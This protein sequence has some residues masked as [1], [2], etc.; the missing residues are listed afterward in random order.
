MMPAA[1]AK[2]VRPEISWM[3]SFGHEVLPMFF[4]GLDADAEFRRGLLVGLAF[5]NQLEHL[6]LARTQES[7]FLLERPAVRSATSDRAGAWQWMGPKNVFPFC[8]SRIARDRSWAEACLSRKPDR[9]G[10]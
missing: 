3:L 6:H 10:P 9:A 2:R 4:D 8:T 7:D 5:G 1:M